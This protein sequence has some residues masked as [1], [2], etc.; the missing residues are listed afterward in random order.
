[1]DENATAA[2]SLTALQHNTKMINDLAVEYS[3]KYIETEK[4]DKTLSDIITS[5][6]YERSNIDFE[7]KYSQETVIYFGSVYYINAFNDA[8]IECLGN[9]KLKSG[10]NSAV[11]YDHRKNATFLTFFERTLKTRNLTYLEKLTKETLEQEEMQDIFTDKAKTI[12]VIKSK[13]VTSDKESSPQMMQVQKLAEI[14]NESI[15]GKTAASKRKPY[16]QVFFSMGIINSSRYVAKEIVVFPNESFIMNLM[17]RDYDNKMMEEVFDTFAELASTDFSSY[18]AENRLLINRGNIQI[19]SDKSIADFF[20]VS[21][22]SV[23]QQK[24]VYDEMCDKVKSALKGGEED[25]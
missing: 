24:K 5:M 12:E 21:K 15:S 7:S 1:M 13:N 8:I 6:L 22:G 17:N 16:P 25:E 23:S 3:I 2:N 18:A 19:L 4:K 10:E 11:I 14:V 20:G 9:K